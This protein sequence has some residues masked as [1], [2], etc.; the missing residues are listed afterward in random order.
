[1]MSQPG[2]VLGSHLLSDGSM[3]TALNASGALPTAQPYAAAPWNY[4]GD[5]QVDAGFFAAHPDVVDWVLVELRDD[6]TTVA[7]RRAAFLRRDGSVVD[8]DG[9]G[10]VSFASLSGTSPGARFVAVFHRN[11]LAA[12]S[13]VAVAPAAGV[14]THDF[15]SGD[16][17]GF[18]PL[19]DLGEGVFGLYAGDGDGDEQVQNDDKNAVWRSQVGLAGY[20]A[21]DFNLNAQ[22]Q[23]DDKNIFWRPNVGRASPVNQ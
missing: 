15:R 11:H 4:A 16:A 3:S 2:H 20:R 7:G 13:P 21:G 5:E 1:M 22:V 14:Y 9:L 8:L 6:A 19:K 23:N 10:L 12:M 18:N 17:I